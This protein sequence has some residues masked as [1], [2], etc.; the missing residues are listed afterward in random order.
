MVYIEIRVYLHLLVFSVLI[1]LVFL[2]S[3]DQVGW[4]FYTKPWSPRLFWNILIRAHIM[5]KLAIRRSR[6]LMLCHPV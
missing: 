6:L 3:T 4:F 1:V 2:W 5:V